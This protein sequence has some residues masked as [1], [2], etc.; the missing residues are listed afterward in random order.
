MEEPSAVRWRA[1]STLASLYEAGR[2]EAPTEA[3]RRS[4]REALLQLI[5]E[6]NTVS[7]GGAQAAH[8]APSRGARWAVEWAAISLAAAAA[9]V[10]C[11]SQPGSTGS[12]QLVPETFATV[13]AQRVA[14]PTPSADEKPNKSV[15]VTMAPRPSLPSSP[16]QSVARPPTA[17]PILSREV[18]LLD[19]ARSALAGGDS[20][21]ALQKLDEYEH[22]LGGVMMQDEARLLRISALEHAGR[23]SESRSLALRFIE[24][25]P[26][27]PLVE[28]AR[29][30]LVRLNE[31]RRGPANRESP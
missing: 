1:E 9:V 11:V 17:P 27:S 7:H 16:G 3:S 13:V 8:R 28:R 26:N 24:E 30:L 4:A 2:G 29:E 25:N 18:E 14:P 31:E 10:W 15:P 5:A 23:R 22:R 20:S 6:K 12:V 19:E 21:S